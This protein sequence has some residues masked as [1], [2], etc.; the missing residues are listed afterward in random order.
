MNYFLCTLFLLTA[1][2][3]AGHDVLKDEGILDLDA[4]LSEPLRTSPIK[5]DL[6]VTAEDPRSGP[7]LADKYPCDPSRSECIRSHDHLHDG[8]NPLPTL[9]D[10]HRRN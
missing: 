10:V 5:N 2:S 4:Q 6:D 3:A 7:T 8:R 9:P 1:F